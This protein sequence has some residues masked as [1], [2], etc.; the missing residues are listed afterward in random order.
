V[1][2][3]ADPAHK[4][5]QGFCIRHG[6][7]RAAHVGLGD[8]LE[9]RCAGAIQVDAGEPLEIFVQRLAGILFQVGTQDANGFGAPVSNDFQRAVLHDRQFVLGN[10]VALGQ[11]GVEVIFS[12]ED[13]TWTDR[14]ANR[15]TQTDCE[16]HCPLIQNRQ[17]TG[18]RDING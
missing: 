12:R 10:L 18:Q 15:Q 13:G 3:A 9:Q 6:F 16:F 14:R 11:V 2:Q 8:D 17:H 1:F 5:M 4:R 7:L